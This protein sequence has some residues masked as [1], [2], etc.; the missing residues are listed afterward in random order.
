MYG[1]SPCFAKASQDKCY[2]KLMEP[3]ASKICPQSL[4][5]FVGQESVKAF[6]IIY[7]SYKMDFSF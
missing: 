4:A 6:D 2:N 1:T 7:F 5:E 3:L